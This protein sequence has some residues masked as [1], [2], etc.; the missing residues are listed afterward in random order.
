MNVSAAKI[1]LWQIQQDWVKF[2]RVA[3]W[4]SGSHFEHT[5]SSVIVPYL[6]ID[7]IFIKI[8]TVNLWQSISQKSGTRWYYWET[9]YNVSMNGVSIPCLQLVC[10]SAAKWNG[11]GFRKTVCKF[12]GHIAAHGRAL[13][14]PRTVARKSST[15][16]FTFLQGGLDIKIDEPQLMYSVSY[17][18]LGGTEHC[19]RGI[20]PPKPPHPLLATG[21]CPPLLASLLCA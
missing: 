13:R 21:L 9:I 10:I 20:R 16:G 2:R 11:E 14:L 1:F 17:F 7:C 18:N 19:L 15:G 6:L 5:G 8:R 3:C 4:R 12:V